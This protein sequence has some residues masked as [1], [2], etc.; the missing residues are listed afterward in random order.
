MKKVLIPLLILF[1]AGILFYTLYGSASSEEAR[2][3]KY[4]EEIIQKRRDKDNFMKHDEQ[5]PLKPEQKESFAGL[6][7]FEPDPAYR[8]EARIEENKKKDLLVLATSDNKQK[9]F[10]KW[11]YAIFTLDGEEHRLLLLQSAQGLKTEGLFLAFSDATSANETYGAGRYLDLEIPK[12][13][14]M[15]IDFNKAYNPYCAYTDGFSCP[16]PP[17]ENNLSVAIRAGEK[18]FQNYD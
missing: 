18:T 10:K 13:K 12:K 6:K 1:V 9:P 5:S 2:E 17:K 11:G 15:I 3:S 8:V 7:Y 4:V 14:T 16:F